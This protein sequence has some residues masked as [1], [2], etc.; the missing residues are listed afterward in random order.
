VSSDEVDPD[1]RRAGTLRADRLRGDAAYRA[2]VERVLARSWHLVAAAD[3]VPT[4]GSASPLV[5]LEGSL[6]EPLVATRDASGVR[7]LLSNV[8]THRANV[9]VERACQATSLRCRYHGRRFGLD[10]RFAHMTEMR[11]A[12]DFPSAADDLARPPTASVGA[13]LFAGVRPEPSFD[14]WWGP[15]RDRLSFVPWDELPAPEPPLDY[16]VHAHF[17]LYCDNYLEGLHIPFVHPGLSRRLDYDAYETELLPRGTLQIGIAAEGDA[18]F[19]LPPGHPD[20]GRRV[21]AYYAFLFPATMI[22]VYPWGLSL[23]AIQPLGPERT[24]VRYH[25][26]VTR[27]ELRGR[28]AGAD[29][30]AVERE[31]DD[32]VESVQRGL[33]SRFYERGRFSPTRETG[34]HHFHRLLEAALERP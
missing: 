18:A 14:A 5:L 9:V 23:N 15:L 32:I 16:E 27:P 11:G 22:N 17:V 2:M 1:V 28:G 4:P 29:L 20:H 8:C 30:G 34:V 3:P 19:E 25:T 26:I 7:H 12:H 24:R 13:L 31:D 10:G 33:R 6:D 21:A